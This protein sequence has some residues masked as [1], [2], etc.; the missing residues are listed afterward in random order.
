MFAKVVDGTNG[1]STTP[2]G[3]PGWPGEYLTP[4]GATWDTPSAE[5]VLTTHS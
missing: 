4:I 1:I 3:W 2:L 5:T